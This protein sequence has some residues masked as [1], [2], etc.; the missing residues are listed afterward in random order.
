MFISG[1]PSNP[2]FIEFEVQGYVSSISDGGSGELAISRRAF[3]SCRT[4]RD[5]S[6]HIRRARAFVCPMPDSVCSRVTCLLP[7]LKSCGNHKTLTER[8]CKRLLSE[9][10]SKL[11][12]SSATSTTSSRHDSALLF[13][14]STRSNMVCYE[15]FPQN[16]DRACARGGKPAFARLWTDMKVSVPLSHISKT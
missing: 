16:L 12:R 2:P 8:F 14:A 10:T 7:T 6:D 13:L 1:V 5:H 3:P 4:V 15:D 11:T 9:L